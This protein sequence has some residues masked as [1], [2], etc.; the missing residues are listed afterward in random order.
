[1]FELTSV[2]AHLLCAR[3]TSPRRAER[4]RAQFSEPLKLGLV[5][6]PGLEP[7]RRVPSRRARHVLGIT[8]RSVYGSRHEVTAGEAGYQRALC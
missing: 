2:T 4:V 5:I 8:V 3:L 6:E 7:A 1:M